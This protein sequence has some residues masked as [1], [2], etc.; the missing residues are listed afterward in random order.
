MTLLKSMESQSYPG[1]GYSDLSTTTGSEKCLGGS[2]LRA[3]QLHTCLLQ[4]KDVV[5]AQTAIVLAQNGIAIE[6]EYAAIY[7][8]NSIISAAVYLPTTQ[9]QP[10]YCIHGPLERFEIGTFPVNA[11]SEAKAKAQQLS[12]IFKAGGATA[13]VF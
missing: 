13:L 6:N 7:P 11:S 3:I 12:D 8:S 1:S 9:T 10:G 5:S 4:S 2:Q